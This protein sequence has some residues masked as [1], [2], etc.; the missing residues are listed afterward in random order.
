MINYRQIWKNYYGSIPKDENGISYQIHHIDGDRSNNDISNL[1]C[2]SIKEHYKIHL[3]QGDFAAAHAIKTKMKNHEQFLGWNHKE[4][5]KQKISK[6]LKGKYIK[7]EESIKR[8]IESKIKNGTIK[9]KE[10][11]K[12]KISQSLKGK[13]RPPMSEEC[14]KKIGNSNKGKKRD[15]GRIG[16]KH[17]EESKMKIGEAN[18]K[19]LKGRKLSEEH[20]LKLKGRI[21]ANKGIPHSDEVRKKI[22]KTKKGRPWTEARILAQKNKNK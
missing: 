20:I 7:S 6:S 18:S 16:A 9:L 3:E 14:K 8:Q 5:T 1:I 4:E 10:E 11:T 15:N 2:I 17:S 22:S 13:K 21:P 12:N 19:S